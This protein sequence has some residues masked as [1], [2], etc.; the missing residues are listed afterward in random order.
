MACLTLY[1]DSEMLL[2][3]TAFMNTLG[4]IPKCMI[5]HLAILKCGV[6]RYFV[7]FIFSKI[8]SNR[9]CH[10]VSMTIARTLY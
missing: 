7:V 5:L 9:V 4:K 3:A 2:I 6:R 10:S 8:N 1:W